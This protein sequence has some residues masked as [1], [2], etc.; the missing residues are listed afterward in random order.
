M[1]TN[2]QQ[3][4]VGYDPVDQTKIRGRINKP[5]PL[6]KGLRS[7]L[8][9]DDN[10]RNS[11]EI[12]DKSRPPISK[13]KSISDI[14]SNNIQATT[15]LRT[16]THYIKRAEQIWVALLMKPNGDQRQLLMYDSE[17]SEVKNGKLHELLLQKLENYFTT[18][19]PF[20]EIAPQIIKDVLFR[21]GSYVQVNMSHAVLDH[22]INGQ[23]IVGSES[24]RASTHDI[25][26]TN[27]VNNDWHRALN[28]GYIRKGKKPTHAL[29]GLESLYGG[30]AHREPEFDLVHNELNWT[31]TDNPVALK[32]GEL[33]QVMR[34]DRL[35]KLAGME[36]IN[37]AMSRVFN[38]KGKGKGKVNPNNVGILEQQTLDEALRE[39]YPQRRYNQNEDTLSVRKG[40]YYTGN[41]RGIGIGYHWP[42]ESCIPCHVNG[43]I[44]KPFGFILL[45]DPDTGSPLKTVSDVKFYQTVKSGSD[46][47]VTGPRA[48]SLNDIIQHI[49]TISNGGDCTEDM[50]W[51][52]EFVS[53]TLEKEI[54]QSFLNGDLNKDISVSLTEENKKLY[55][56]RALKGQGVRAI[57]VPSEYVT[58][59]ATDWNK[60]G[61]GRSLVDEAKLHITRL[62]VIETATALAQVENSISHTLLEITPEE[63]DTDVRNTA[64][65]VRDEWFAGNPGMHEILG[66]NSVSIDSIL[67]RLKEQSITVKVNAGNNPHT[68]APEVT[69]SQQDREPIKMPDSELRETLLNTISGFFGL[70]RS[71][72]E[73]TGEGNDFA[74]EALADQELLR[75][76]TTEY[77]RLFSQH[78]TDIMRKHIAV[79]E[80][81]LGELV[82]VIR[83][84]KALYMKSDQTGKVTVEEEDEVKKAE[85]E[86]AEE[87]KSKKGKKK[88]KKEKEEDAVIENDTGKVVE[89]NE[90]DIERIHLVLAD[91]MNTFYVLLPTPAITDSLNKLEDK[92][93]AVEKLVESWVTL[94]GGAKMLKRRADEIGLNGDD[95]I[96][97]F[98]AVLFHE[99]FE[100][101]NLPMPFEAILNK[102]KTGG[103]M[104]YVNKA[105]DLDKN[106]LT[107]LGEWVKTLDSTQNKVTNLT[108]KVAKVTAPDTSMDDVP[109]DDGN[110]DD[111]PIDG[112]GIPPG[113][114]LLEGNDNTDLD[115]PP[116]EGDA[117]LAQQ[118]ELNDETNPGD[119]DD[120]WADQ[121][122]E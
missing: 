6:D 71:W 108:E 105:A 46:A 31:F 95:V 13:I 98:K 45:V 93:E 58:Y 4:P 44:G 81:L 24:F 49:K 32:I 112:D 55:L 64:A 39:L 19:M 92:I 76:Q 43:E 117:N 101:F 68:V 59:V 42:S 5:S 47:A 85:E 27:F 30:Q 9:P 100:R 26:Q 110:T 37:S 77:S 33:A 121:T 61:V 38:K 28:V 34:E 57:F 48:G 122:K 111:L 16:I 18:V 36:S 84:N 52:A 22:L 80:P 60:L 116:N 102:G 7:L 66:Y 90:D 107:F 15:D 79:N 72:L 56:A 25:L 53:A 75:N 109:V 120:L 54:V 115:A 67:D 82:E 51:M 65:I 29:A 12:K 14:V 86:A 94:G 119:G 97:N 118:S 99:A 113:D 70:K 96:E 73:D 2:N 83:E 89:D 10:L 35:A 106:I 62:A 23:E 8:V 87:E 103:M 1:S 78:F 40:K 11:R 3:L 91:F 114:D 50:D 20:E 17:S 88:D 63:E 69:A 41:G 74:I 104:T 21:T